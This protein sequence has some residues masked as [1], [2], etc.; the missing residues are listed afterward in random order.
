EVRL[1]SATIGSLYVGD[2]SVESKGDSAIN[3]DLLHV[4]GDLILANCFKCQGQFRARG[5]IVDM[6][7]V[8]NGATI[9][10]GDKRAIDLRLSSIN[11]NLLMQHPFKCRG[12]AS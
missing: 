5:A 6:D 12:E 3:L 9:K 8:C 7:A 2:A 10:N 4:K 1:A 11:G